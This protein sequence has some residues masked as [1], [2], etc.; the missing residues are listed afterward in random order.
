[1]SL[2]H[3]MIR[4]ASSRRVRRLAAALLLATVLA[5]AAVSAQQPAPQAQAPPAAKAPSPAPART[6]KVAVIDVER[7]LLESNRGKKALGEIEA[8]RKQKQQEGDAKQKEI[9]D[10]RQKIKDGQLSLSEDKLA[11]LKKQLED[12]LIALQRFQDDAQRD[13][14][15]K[16]D[17]VLDQIEKSVFPV[18]NKIGEEGGYTMI[19][20]KY[21][22]GLVYADDSVDITEQ[23]IARYNQ[24]TSH[25]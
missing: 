5:P 15:K 11:D 2:V 10:L 19:F 24:T 9:T 23:V 22:S 21:R 25:Q 1:M 12:K 4:H 6:A 14:S 16:R 3:R 13:L 7:I 20:N 17:E 8:V 18:I